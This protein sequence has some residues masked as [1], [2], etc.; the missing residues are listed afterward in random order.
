M[1]RNLLLSTLLL[2]SASMAA[3]GFDGSF[4]EPWETCYPDGVNAVGLQP[5]GWMASNVYKFFLTSVKGELVK[6]DKDRTEDANGHSVVMT[7]EFV[8]SFG[9]GA[10]APGYITLGKSWAY[11]DIEATLNPELEDTSDGGA[12]GGVEFT[13]RPDSLVFWVKRTHVAEAPNKGPFNPDEKASVLFYSWTGSTTSKVTTGLS[14]DKIE[15]DMVDRE[16]DILGMVTE[17]VT[18]D[19]K[20]VAFNEYYIEENIE[21]WTRQSV[22]IDYKSDGN[23]EKMNIIFSASDYFNRSELGTG[24]ALYVDDVQLV[25]NSRLKSLVVDGKEV[26]GF[27]DGVFDYQLPADLQGKDIV[28][29]AFGKDATVETVT[30]GNVTTITVKDE[31]AMGEKVNTYT[32]MFKGVSAEIQLPAE[33]PALTYGDEVDGLGFISN[34]TKDALAYSFSKEGV[35][36]VGEDGKVRA[37]GA[38]EVV[39]T[40]SQPGS[41]DFTPAES[42][43]MTLTVAKAPLNVSLAD[44][45]WTWRGIAVSTSNMDKGKCHYIF[46]YD[47]WKWN[48]AEKGASEVLSKLPTVSAS[49]PKDAEAVGS[50]RAAKLS[51]GA[52]ENYDL[53]FAEDA[54]FKVVKNKVG[55]YVKYGSNTLSTAYDDEKYRTVNAAV[56]QEEYIFTTG[57]SDVVYD[58]EDVLAA[59]ATQPEVVCNVNKDAVVGDEFPVSVKLPEKVSFDNFE[60]VSIVPDVA[61]LVMAESPG[62]TVTV[63]ETVTYGDEFTLVTNEHGI[64][65]NST[66][67]TSG[68]VSMTTKGVVTAKK[69]G[70]AELVVT[71]TPKTVDGVDYGA[72]TTRVA[73]DIQKAALTIKASDVEVNLDGDLPETYE[74]VYEGFVNKDKAETVFTDMPVATVNLPEPLTAGTYPI[75]VSVSEEPENYVVTT[76]DGTLTVKDGSSVAG[77]SSKNDKVTYAN[78][79][80]Y[81][82]CGGR[83][84][85]YALTGTLVGRYEGAVIPVA[86][87]TNTLYIVKTQ[88]GAFRL[89]VK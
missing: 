37:V 20:L 79:N 52:A 2:A 13:S 15:V 87:R 44:D 22:A 74:L 29:T 49:A 39:V 76:V 77:V 56:G 67:L 58:D 34:N 38:G 89:W 9:I 48:D 68:V 55:V 46:V 21:I 4:D 50:E 42:E 60:L 81:V 69:A 73:F 26:N 36:E 32:L 16:K 30:E 40:A 71:T 61:K 57:Y 24:N 85:I 5:K 14:T 47:G 12:Y 82:P 19:A 54:K 51:G 64:T 75:K 27:S 6:P 88:K 33:I 18:G 10:T 84:E 63:P 86:L 78:G 59:L 35:L 70:K 72:T 31:T 45:A 66:V 53:K 3:Q 43:P 1:K 23:P 62:I 7:N 28:A 25:Y 83:V 65:Y 17:G 41:D 80:L 11:G 8:G